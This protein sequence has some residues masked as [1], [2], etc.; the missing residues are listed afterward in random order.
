[1]NSHNSRLCYGISIS[2]GKPCQNYVQSGYFCYHHKDQIG[3]KNKYGE[4]EK[5]EKCS[6]FVLSVTGN[7]ASAYFYI[8]P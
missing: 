2:T 8:K 7:L 6:T 1:M 3:G 4:C 5:C